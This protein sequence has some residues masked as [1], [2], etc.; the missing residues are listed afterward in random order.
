MGNG[1]AR[2]VAMWKKREVLPTQGIMS[3][4]DLWSGWQFGYFL[5]IFCT[6]FFARFLLYYLFVL[7]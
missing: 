5:Y 7:R 3:Q 2:D 4:D 1:R 6:V